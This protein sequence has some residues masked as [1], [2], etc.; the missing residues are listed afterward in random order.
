LKRSRRIV[1][2][3]SISKSFG[4]SGTA[5]SDQN[6]GV[7]RSNSM[8]RPRKRD[9]LNDSINVPVRRPFKL[10]FVALSAS[11]GEK[12]HTAYARRLLEQSVEREL[13]TAAGK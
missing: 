12:S 11:K 8:S 2:A 1:A 5:S 4:F 6:A 10:R 9:K 13:A 7:N 3:R